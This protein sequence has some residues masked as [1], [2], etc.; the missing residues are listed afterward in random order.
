MTTPTTRHSQRAWRS[1]DATRSLLTWKLAAWQA[2]ET[3]GPQGEG[4]LLSRRPGPPQRNPSMKWLTVIRPTRQATTVLTSSSCEKNELTITGL[5]NNRRVDQQR[6]NKW[7]LI[8]PWENGSKQ[9]DPENTCLCGLYFC[10][11][12]LLT[13]TLIHMTLMTKSIIYPIN[14]L[15]DTINLRSSRLRARTRFH[16]GRRDGNDVSLPTVCYARRETFLLSL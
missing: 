9:W 10:A 1:Q 2:R 12:N 8:S 6:V 11:N 4:V 5:N 13:Y 15:Y 7:K 3:P 14:C 16:W